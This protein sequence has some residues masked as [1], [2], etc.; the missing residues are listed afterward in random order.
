MGQRSRAVPGQAWGRGW[1]SLGNV[2]SRNSEFPHL[3][4]PAPP[5]P[6]WLRGAARAVPDLELGWQDP[7]LQAVRARRTLAAAFWETASLLAWFAAL[8]GLAGLW[9]ALL[10]WLALS[11]RMG[12]V[13]VAGL[14]GAPFVFTVLVRYGTQ[15]EDGA[16]P[17]PGFPAA[18]G[19]PT[20]RADLASGEAWRWERWRAMPIDGAR[21]ARLVAAERN[22]SPPVVPLV[23]VPVAVLAGVAW[24]GAEMGT[25]TELTIWLA[26]W[27][28]FILLPV[29]LLARVVLLVNTGEAMRHAAHQARRRAGLAPPGRVLEQGA[30]WAT[31]RAM[32]IAGP[33][34]AIWVA[35][36]WLA[37]LF[38]LLSELVVPPTAPYT[39]FS[40]INCTLPFGLV[41]WFFLR[42]A[43]VRSALEHYDACH[44]ALAR[45]W[46]RVE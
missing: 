31:I 4:D 29:V 5:V 28:A 8:G 43:I 11:G 7:L 22:L 24:I 20:L 38:F 12:W 9:I 26:Y 34:A 19:P 14:L 15:A 46:D 27:A 16:R 21:A 36:G 2:S 37:S 6:W 18:T 10:G 32:R 42:E 35:L 45:E 3:A 30:V 40:T 25:Y 13:A 33:I 17:F 41:G 23:V 44:A 39:L 1:G